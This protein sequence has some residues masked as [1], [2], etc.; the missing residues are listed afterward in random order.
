M[1][2][3]WKYE[4]GQCLQ[5]VTA[6]KTWEGLGIYYVL[7]QVRTIGGLVYWCRVLDSS[8]HERQRAFFDEYE[9][10]PYVEKEAKK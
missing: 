4:I 2:D 6:T 3:T 10:V 9:L 1:T 5:H 7:A 8:G